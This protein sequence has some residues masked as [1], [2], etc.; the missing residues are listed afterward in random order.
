MPSARPVAPWSTSSCYRMRPAGDSATGRAF[1]SS[2]VNEA[3]KEER[4]VNPSGSILTFLRSI[5]AQGFVENSLALVLIAIVCIVVPKVV[6]RDAANSVGQ[7]GNAL[8]NLLV[9]SKMR[10]AVDS[11]TGRTFFPS[12][13][14]KA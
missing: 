4:S 13:D 3:R 11:T 10:P 12:T 6:S 8:G 9:A 2:N 5:K 14:N 1:I 7:D